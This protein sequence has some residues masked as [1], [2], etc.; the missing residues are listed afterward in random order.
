MCRA[1]LRRVEPD[2][3]LDRAISGEAHERV[4][5]PPAGELVRADVGVRVVAIDVGAEEVVPWIA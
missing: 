3:V 1:V 2:R 5:A 4:F